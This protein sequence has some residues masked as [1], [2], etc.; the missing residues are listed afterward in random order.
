MLDEGRRRV[1]SRRVHG[2][3]KNTLKGD[4]I[5]KGKGGVTKIWKREQAGARD[6]CLK[7]GE[8]AETL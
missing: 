5:E 4:R 3:V 8:A 6:R 7:K 2:T 1:V